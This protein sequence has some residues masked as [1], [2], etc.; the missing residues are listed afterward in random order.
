MGA[1]SWWYWWKWN[2]RSV[3]QTGIWTSIHRTW[4]SL[5]HLSGSCQESFQGQDNQRPQETLGFLKWS[6]T[7]KGI[8]Q[9]PSANKPR[10]L[11]DLNRDQLWWVVGLL[12]RNCHLK[13]HLFKL[14]LTNVPSAKGAQKKEESATHIL[15]DREAI[16]YLRFCHMGHYFM[17]SSN[18]HDTP[19]KK[20]ICFIR[21][22]GLIEG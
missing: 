20:V 8:T 5:H 16:A 3:G 13:G 11:L 12:T 9:G 10:E 18:Y 17:G 7:G 22:A 4:T 2:S 15:C 14:R 1:S 6:L 21:S 19:M